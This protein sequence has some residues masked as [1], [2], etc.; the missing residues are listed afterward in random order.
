VY[1]ENGA[2]VIDTVAIRSLESMPCATLVALREQSKARFQVD[3]ETG[4][5]DY[6]LYQNTVPVGLWKAQVC[7]RTSD[8]KVPEGSRTPRR[9]PVDPYLYVEVSIHKAMAG[10][11]VWGGPEGWLDSLAWL[12]KELEL[13]CCVD[14]PPIEGWAV[15]RVDWAEV[16]DLG[17]ED[18]V[19][20][21][22]EARKLATYPRRAVQFFGNL[23]L[24]A[25]GSTTSLKAYAKG[26]E[27]MTSGGF[28]RMLEVNDNEAR[29]LQA[30]S[31]QYLRCEVELKR[32]KLDNDYRQCL[33]ADLSEDYLVDSYDLEWYRFCKEGRQAGEIVRKSF[34]V[35]ERL[36]GR[37]NAAELYG[38][39]M[40]LSCRGEDFY[41]RAVGRDIF[42]RR[43]R[44]LSRLGISWIDTDLVISQESKA[45]GF[46]PSRSAPERIEGRHPLV[47]LAE[48]EGGMLRTC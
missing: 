29:Q 16:F 13:F 26:H 27:F 4:E 3:A 39:W 47:V 38:T 18:A 46:I 32:E 20:A 41:K 6:L 21:W 35:W 15:R 11:N 9:M 31:R 2:N 48:A 36:E 5:V 10:H 22:I 44:A 25:D 33:V 8:F 17:S 19:T 34:L 14:L 43:R 28:R 24:R 40:I 1:S 42:Y 30:D 23:G 45:V 7:L 12:H 37:D